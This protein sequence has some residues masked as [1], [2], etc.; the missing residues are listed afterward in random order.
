MRT[1]VL[2][3][4]LMSVVVLSGWV[5]LRGKNSEKSAMV[6]SPVSKISSQTPAY[7]EEKDQK[8]FSVDGEK[9]VTLKKNADSKGFTEYTLVTS[10]GNEIFNK[11]VGS[12]TSI[13]LPGNSWDPGERYVFVEQ[14]ENDKKTDYVIKTDGESFSDTETVLDVAQ[15]FNEKKFP[16]Y[17]KG[18]TGWAGDD[19]LIIET[20]KDDASNGP[21]YW[22]E[23][24]SRAFIQ[25]Y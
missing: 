23:V 8:A 2:F 3:I 15:L 20:V 17:F 5:L 1:K 13:S 24:S 18:A 19:L 21:L 6:S 16:Y 14:T 22:F 10:D 4:A 12:F 7:A 9:F 11:N 25:L